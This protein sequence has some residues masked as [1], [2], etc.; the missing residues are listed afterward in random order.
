ML[1][2]RLPGTY[3]LVLHASTTQRIVVGR[4]GV[5]V[6]QPGW[7]VYVGSALG[8]GGLAARIRHHAH[9]ALRPR[10]HIDYLRAVTDLVDA[11]YTSDGERHEH[12]WARLLAHMPGASLAMSGFGASD[13][14]CVAHLFV[15][16]SAPQMA[17]FRTAA[18]ESVCEKQL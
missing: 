18:A 6:V 4:L 15:F 7:Y 16:A 5:L 2:P 11:W 14:N 1:P 9:P 3:A 13:C 8:P 17:A 12:E 10:W